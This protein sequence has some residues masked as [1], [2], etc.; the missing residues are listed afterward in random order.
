[1][2]AARGAADCDFNITYRPSLSFVAAYSSASPAR[3][4]AADVE[5]LHTWQSVDTNAF[6]TIR[7]SVLEGGFKVLSV[8]GKF[9]RVEQRYSSIVG[10]RTGI[11]LGGGEW[12]CRLFS[13]VSCEVV[14]I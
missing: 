14:L 2:C 1:M 4:L 3:F 8:G 9:I 11:S 13:S 5:A 6:R 10:G 7:G 12:I